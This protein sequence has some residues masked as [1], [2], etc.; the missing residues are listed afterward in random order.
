M[1]QRLIPDLLWTMEA[2]SAATLLFM[3]ATFFGEPPAEAMRWA[4]MVFMLG[5]S[6][7]FTPTRSSQ[8]LVITFVMALCV[9]IAAHMYSEAINFSV[10]FCSALTVACSAML[11]WTVRG[12]MYLG[13]RVLPLLWLFYLL[14]WAGL[15]FAL[16][17][18][19][20]QMNWMYLPWLCIGFA[21]LIALFISY[22]FG[23]PGPNSQL[24]LPPPS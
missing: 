1:P 5:A 16:Y 2:V 17:F 13:W 7:L 21:A 24:T 18:G 3:G 8:L 10:I 9:P 23:N 6:R 15:G 4:G 11:A 12:E 14:P 22:A 20:D 19:A